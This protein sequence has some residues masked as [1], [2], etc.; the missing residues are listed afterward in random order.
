MS[1]ASARQNDD[2]L[3]QEDSR[4]ACRDMWAIGLRP[5]LANP[6]SGMRLV[7]SDLCATDVNGIRYGSRIGNG[8]IM[9]SYGDWD[10]R[11][12][13]HTLK[14]PLLVVHG[15]RETIPMDMVE[16]WVTSMPKGM[17]TLLRV[18][19]AAHFTYAERPE[20]VWPAVERFLAA[21]RT[22]H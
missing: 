10:L 13:L 12:A 3:S 15:E 1:A 4:Q 6:R 17:A 8:V 19:R 2:K 11:P 16:E 22:T 20:L 5:R 7:K 14:V 18:P 21:N 9:R